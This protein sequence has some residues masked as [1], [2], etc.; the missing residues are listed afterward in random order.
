MNKSSVIVLINL[1][2]YLGGGETLMI[3]FAEYLK[4]RGME[5]IC[6]CIQGGYLYKDLQRIGIK[7]DSILPI[8]SSPD[9]FYESRA[10]RQ[11]LIDSIASKIQ[12][13]PVRFV[14][15]C[16]RDLHIVRKV[17]TKFPHVAIAHLILHI[18]D[19]LYLGQTL[20][21]KIIY[22]LIRYRRF[23]NSNIIKFNR[24]LL[25]EVNDNQGLICMS[26][27][28]ATVWQDNFDIVI[29]SD[30]IVPL[31]SFLPS[32]YGFA[33]KSQNRKIIWIGRIVDFKIPALLA[34]IDFIA[35][36]NEYSLTI[37]GDGDRSSIIA[38]MKDRGVALGRVNFAGE[39]PYSKLGEFILGH[40]VGYA[41]GT[42]LIELARF[43]I[44]VII[45]LASF[46]H[47]PFDRP[48]CGGLFFDQPKGTDGSELAI[49]SEKEIEN[50]IANTID[51][52]EKNW[53]YIGNAC[54]EY[55]YSNYSIEDNFS[56][57]EK[58]ITNTDWIEHKEKILKIPR[59][60]LVRKL[61]YKLHHKAG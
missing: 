14:S 6:V 13:R 60:S 1:N 12:V 53:E 45:A 11:R 58:I 19:D 42:S 5:F 61:A 24:Q 51:V 32:P 31:P 57:Y 18:Q 39:V 36:K 28:I 27:L 23:G 30:R 49:R 38:R 56:K 2:S 10:G 44:P 25:N 21:D 48:I 47:A 26:D 9:Y 8:Q 54:Y 3:R 43:R 22:S 46:T 35:T 52:I 59:A 7:K 17:C 55:A 4:R 15:F 40:S 37:V 41:M 33:L 34:M 20:I 50:T 29:P 16:M